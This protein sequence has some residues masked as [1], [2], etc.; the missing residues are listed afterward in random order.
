MAAKKK[1]ST[2]KSTQAKKSSKTS[3]TAKKAVKKKTAAKAS[4][5]VSSKTKSSKTAAT[6]K[7]VAKTSKATKKTAKAVK[8]QS[9]APAKA[10]TKKAAPKKSAP[11]KKDLTPKEV[12]EA[13]E[14]KMSAEE[15]RRDQAA[16]AIQEALAAKQQENETQEDEEFDPE[17]FFAASGGQGLFRAHVIRKERVDVSISVRFRISRDPL[18]HH[19]EMINLS[20][21]GFCLKTDKEVDGDTEIRIEIPLPHTSELFSVKGKCVWSHAVDQDGMIGEE[22]PIHTG[23]IFLPMSLAKQTVINNF[24][25]QRRDELIMAKIGLDKFSDSVPVAGLD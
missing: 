9:K 22:A 21:G 20:K 16:K 5:K 19:A 4:K 8:K 7:K 13:P 1:V 23:F 24:I 17:A 14:K 15:A 11:A 25:Q 12:K 2:K 10:T 18:V 3:K 6:K